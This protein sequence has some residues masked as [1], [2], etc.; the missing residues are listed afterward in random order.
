[1]RKIYFLTAA[2]LVIIVSS[3]VCAQATTMAHFEKNNY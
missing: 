2:L 3:G 1:M